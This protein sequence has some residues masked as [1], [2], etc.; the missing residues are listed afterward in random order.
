MANVNN[1]SSNSYS[2][3]TSLYG[4]RNVLT[5]LASGMDTET[6]IQN[7]VA[8]YQTK[9]T[10]LKQDQTK[11]EWKQDAYRALTD[12]MYNIT[13][14]YTSYT[15]KTNLSSNGFF[16]SAST[17]TAQGS[18]AS[19][20]TATGTAKS[21]VQIN[22]VTQLA[23]AARYT[24]RAS[25]LNYN[26]AVNLTGKAV[27][28]VGS[29]QVSAIEG[30][31]TLT[32]GSERFTLDF[33]ANDV[34]EDASALVNGINAKLQE[35][36]AKVSASLSDGK[37]TFAST[38]DNGDSV[39]LSGATGNFK[40]QLGVEY[41][42]SSAATNRF[43][44][45]NIQ[46]GDKALTA[47]KSMADYLSDRTIEVTLDGTTKKISVGTLDAS[48]DTPLADQIK[49]NLQTNLNRAFGS[50]AVT[51]DTENGA[52]KF[53]VKDGSG[54][55]LKLKSDIEE[56][57]LD[58]GLSNYFDTSNTL[59]K[60]LGADY[61]KVKGD[62]AVTQD[63]EGV[64]HDARGNRTDADGYLVDE[65]GNTIYEEKDLVVNGVNLGKFGKD[66]A[67][68]RVMNTINSSA[69][70]GITASYSKL[71]GEFL[72]T[73]SNTGANQTMS[74]GDGLATRL[75]GTMVK[76][77]E[78][79]LG[80]VL[81]DDWF[82]EDGTLSLKFGSNQSSV[83][84]LTKDSTLDDLKSA[85][86][87]K[88]GKTKISYD[89]E[90]D[91]YSVSTTNDSYSSV[92]EIMISA[93]GKSMRLVDALQG[94]SSFSDGTDAIVSA[95]VNGKQL[96]LQRASNVIDMDGM[97]VTLKNTFEGGEAVTF[98]TSADSDK[99]VDTVK[100]FVEDINK[101]M[102]DVHDAYATRPAEKS[103]KK[104]TK[105]EPLTDEDKADM[106]ESAVKAYEEKAK[107][108][109]LF[110]D[111][112]VSTLYD[113]LRSTIEASGQTRID[114]E[115]IGITSAYSNGV[116]TFSLNEEKLRAALDSNPDKVKNVFA[117]TQDSNGNT[118]GLME[119]FK[120]TLNAYASTSLGSPGILV[121]KAG[122]KLSAV[123]LLNNNLQKQLDN[124]SNQIESWETKLSSKIDYYTKQFT[125]L[126]KMISTMNNQSSMLGDLMG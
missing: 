41:A 80:D 91:Q 7:S 27:S 44:Y 42:S 1:I 5:G 114:M 86:N 109:L 79:K 104:H 17:T 46:V 116:T 4:N 38:S 47:E 64:Y 103:A 43:D 121:S 10:T 97:S 35:Q 57:G 105:Y 71:T 115:A 24:V 92:D 118:N 75:F 37:I 34:Y 101:L 18:N 74:F 53:G 22:A 48:S 110:G 61:F 16:T 25:T 81:G 60:L 8:G 59:D 85:V 40:T 102:Q 67:L 3:S 106:S 72:F 68:D 87:S 28:S 82:N 36:G 15:S 98:K 33:D 32:A 99:I 73:S 83:S 107:Q 49:A 65:E 70:V 120:K 66:A 113:R 88:F 123:S 31:L 55:S 52:L 90:T 69:D 124:I 12:Q 93:N 50:G 122:T 51:V 9:L 126:E 23:T 2:S 13:Q 96:T 56:L 6:M 14:K 30:S 84:G 78:Q 21:D 62:G 39:Y 26:N 45:N 58:A 94:Y 100:G 29:K 63:E 76:H 77:N 125:A 11:I 117:T 112:D 95:T 108:G 119:R 20:I 54:S 19:A 111:T 89:T